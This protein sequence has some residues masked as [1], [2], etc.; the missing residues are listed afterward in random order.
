MAVAAVAPLFGEDSSNILSEAKWACLLRS[1]YLKPTVRR[2]AIHLYAK[3]R[4]PV[5]QSHHPALF[6]DFGYS[7]ISNGKTAPFA[8][9]AFQTVG[10]FSQHQ[11]AL[12]R[13]DTPQG[14]FF[15]HQAHRQ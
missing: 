10:V 3:D 5:S 14:H 4:L 15:G 6:V 7:G 9:I 11:K 2:A 12:D 8:N 13:P 1:L